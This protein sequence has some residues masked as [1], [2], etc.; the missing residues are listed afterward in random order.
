MLERITTI[1]TERLAETVAV[2]EKAHGEW[3]TL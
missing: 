2:G 1:F 3:R